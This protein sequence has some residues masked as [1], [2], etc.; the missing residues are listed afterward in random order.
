MSLKI[1]AFIARKNTSFTNNDRN[2]KQQVKKDP[3]VALCRRCHGTGR[4]DTGRLFRRAEAC[5][6]CEGSGRVT[7]SAEM[8]LDIRP[9][10][11]K[12]KPVED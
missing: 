10:K 9:C 6:Q 4:I 7:V 2:M 5:P 1:I 8:A 3:K 11:P 12:E